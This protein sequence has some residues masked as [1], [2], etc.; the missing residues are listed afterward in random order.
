MVGGPVCRPTATEPMDT[1]RTQDICQGL[2][3]F[4]LRKWIL[5]KRCRRQILSINLA[6]EIVLFIDNVNVGFI[7]AL[8]YG[9]CPANRKDGGRSQ[10]SSETR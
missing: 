10:T 3:K 2:F 6:R 4:L 7:R 5:R 9:G 1:I 8:A